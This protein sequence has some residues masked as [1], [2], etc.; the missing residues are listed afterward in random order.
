MMEKEVKKEKMKLSDKIMTTLILLALIAG[1]GYFAYKHFV[2]DAANNDISDVEGIETYEVWNQYYTYGDDTYDELLSITSAMK[3]S[4]ANFFIGE[5]SDYFNFETISQTD[6]TTFENTIE[7]VS[8]VEIAQRTIDDMKMVLN[9]DFTKITF[10]LEN[11]EIEELE[12][13]D[14]FPVVQN[15]N[16]MTYKYGNEGLAVYLMEHGVKL[17]CE[18]IKVNKVAA[19]NYYSDIPFSP[20]A[21]ICAIGTA[22]VTTENAKGDIAELGLFGNVGETVTINFSSIG[23][24]A[25]DVRAP[26]ITQCFTMERAE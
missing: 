2:L 11:Y 9:K 8:S 16:A 21:L 6:K 20:V 26:G 15:G 22:E 14:R 1:G 12:E 23:S 25:T 24:I 17:K 18:S 7:R 10:G 13:Q 4:D 19:A 3:Y 5:S